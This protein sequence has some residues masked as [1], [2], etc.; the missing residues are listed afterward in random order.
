MT[1]TDD[2]DVRADELGIRL[3]AWMTA[4]AP[5]REPDGLVPWAVDRTVRVRQRP[6]LLIRPAL[7]TRGPTWPDFSPSV[8][9][10]VVATVVLV[11]VGIVA[12]VGARLLVPPIRVYVEQL[13]LAGTFSS[14]SPDASV[15]PLPDGDVLVV[16][17]ILAEIFDPTTG[18]TRRAGPGYRSS[19]P[20]VVVPLLDGRVLL[21]A[22]SGDSAPPVAQVYDPRRD[23]FESTG[24]PQT[25]RH[26]P[27]VARLADG[28]VLIAGG[29]VGSV[30]APDVSAEVYDPADGTFTP[31]GDMIRPRVLHSMT[32][33]ADGR[34]L[35][36]G[37]ES[38]GDGMA[39]VYDPSTGTF[40]AAGRRVDHAALQSHRTALV[41]PVVLADGRVVVFGVDEGEGCGRHGIEPIGAEFFDPSTDSFSPAPPVAHD[42]RTAT[43]LDDGRI[44]VTGEWQA[45]P[46]GCGSGDA[47]V[48]DAWI[49]TYDPATGETRTSLD[50]ITGA[51][52]FGTDTDAVYGDALRL[53]DGRVLLFATSSPEGGDLHHDIDVFE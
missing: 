23:A 52:T 12:I 40:Q 37:G 21:I 18:V 42:P 17:S 27:S 49:G 4:S 1:T 25:A 35:V 41:A 9:S 36:V 2:L 16:G 39:E 48:R 30:L 14:S 15:A 29:E 8:R 24:V 5:R 33:L 3:A 32:L 46:G 28:R 38:D 11:I 53:D 50:P 34:V 6:A 22:W 51:S 45:L 43:L 26:E 31:T 10:A 19:A 13:Q 47:Y 20:M 44:L 7:G